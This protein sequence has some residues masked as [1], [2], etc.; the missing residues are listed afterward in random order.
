MRTPYT[1]IGKSCYASTP[2]ETGDEKSRSAEVTCETYQP[3]LRLLYFFTTVFSVSTPCKTMN[4][5]NAPS[6][7]SNTATFLNNRG[8]IFASEMNQLLNI[9]LTLFMT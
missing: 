4:F 5:E 9:C 7:L 2:E 8:V 1:K 3:T 6:H